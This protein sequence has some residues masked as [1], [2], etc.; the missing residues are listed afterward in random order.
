MKFPDNNKPQKWRLSAL[1]AALGA[2]LLIAACGGGGGGGGSAGG[3][4]GQVEFPVTP[5]D[6]Q[7]AQLLESTLGQAGD[8]DVAINAD[9]V[10]YAIWS[11]VANGRRSIF[12][13]RYS[14]GVWKDLKVVSNFLND[15][16][17]P[18]VVVQPNGQAMAIWQELQGTD[19]VLMANRT[20]G[21]GAD[22]AVPFS[23]QA[24]PEVLDD[25]EMVVDGSSNAVAIWRRAQTV[26]AIHF[27]GNQFGLPQQISISTN[28]GAFAADVAMGADGNALAVW[29]EVGAAATNRV[30]A[31]AFTN[32]VWDGEV[33][34]N[35]GFTGGA[36]GG[37]VSIGP[38]GNAVVV[39][40]QSQGGTNDSV[41]ARVSNN[42]SGKQWGL[43]NT[44]VAGAAVGAT[45]TM[46]RQGRAVAAW[47]QTEGARFDVH[48]VRYDGA[49]W[50]TPEKIE[51]DDAGNAGSVKLGVDALGG[52]VALW[53]QNDG[54]RFNIVSNR[55]NLSTGKWGTPEFI[56]TEDKGNASFAALAVS[57]GGRAVAAW[58]QLNGVTDLAGNDVTS[59]MGN[60]FK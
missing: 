58:E 13:M 37:S 8:V 35:E 59:V 44:L 27:D 26:F 56:E 29:T 53:E 5:A 11:Q 28:A 15:A 38:N 55:L 45:V 23:L 1:V 51:T 12:T 9:G 48:A 52:A 14:D 54:T 32:G 21:P 18:Q 36:G 57:V 30:F 20:T 43:A 41:V 4:G 49:N 31:R 17:A 34:I 6:W 3:G 19:Q 24:A 22:W 10:A 16:F 50:L 46:D 2:S 7:V 47:Q 39:W 25:L 33:E 40:Q 42:V 60:V